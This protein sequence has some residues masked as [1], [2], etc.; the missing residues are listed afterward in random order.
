[1]SRKWSEI[2]ILKRKFSEYYKEN[3]SIIKPPKLLNKR[4]F[5]FV[6]FDEKIVIRHQGFEEIGGLLEFIKTTTPSDVYYSAAYYRD[7]K[8]EMSKKGWLGADL[9]FDIDA[10]HIQTPCKT[11][12]DIWICEHCGNV[13]KGPI[14]KTCPYCGAEK[15]KEKTWLCDKC[16]EAAKTETMKLIEF[17]TDDLG[18]ITDDIDV[19]FSGHRGYHVHITNEAVRTMNQLARK[20]ITDYVRGTG[21]LVE[22]QGLKEVKLGGISEVIGPDL[23]DPG[24]RG[25]AARGVYDIVINAEKQDLEKIEGLKRD[26]IELLITNREVLSNIWKENSP[27]KA[28]KGVGIKTWE[29]IVKHAAYKQAAKIDT[30]VTTDIHRLMRMPNT[31]HGKTGLKMTKIKTDDLEKFDPLTESIA[32]QKGILPIFV[33]NAYEFRLGDKIYGPYKDEKVDLPTAA[34]IFLLCKGVARLEGE[35]E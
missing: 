31:L 4:E 33:S 34:A 29:K 15:L 22:L 30:V 1:M 23:Y 2:T 9:V 6:L 3:T 32:F 10:D 17:L 21:F 27:W 8:E 19:Y 24:W 16:L 14:P 11:E 13:G 5:G 18:F 26:T 7:P 25:R 12:H 28:L 20:E 35:I